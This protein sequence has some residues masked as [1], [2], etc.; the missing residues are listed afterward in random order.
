MV[1]FCFGGI[2][3]PHC[4]EPIAYLGDEGWV[5][6]MFESL[7]WCPH[8]SE[9]FKL[10]HVE[11]DRWGKIGL[12]EVA[13]ELNIEADEENYAKQLALDLQTKQFV[14]IF[15]DAQEIVLKEE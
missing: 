2:L 5:Q 12:G 8:C 11:D 15:D 6:E 4:M 14:T 3:C 13:I 1:R 10:K 9:P 7:V